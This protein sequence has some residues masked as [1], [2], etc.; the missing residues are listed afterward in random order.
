L[1]SLLQAMQKANQLKSFGVCGTCRH[2]RLEPDGSRWCGLTLEALQPS[3]AEKI[4]REHTAPE[5]TLN[6][7]R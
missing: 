7:A 2:H 1:Q 6:E 4:C 5:E 3:D